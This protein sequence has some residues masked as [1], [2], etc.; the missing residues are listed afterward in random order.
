[1]R[2]RC[3]I[4]LISFTAYQDSELLDAVEKIASS[5]QVE[6]LYF[7]DSRG[8]VYPEE[9]YT[10]YSD[11]REI[12]R[13]PL[14]FHA[15]DNLGLAIE[16]SK[17]ALDAGCDLIDCSIN[18]YG[19]GGRNTEFVQ[20]I[21]LVRD[22]RPDLQDVGERE[23]ESVVETIGMPPKE[24]F[25]DLYYLTGLKNLEQEWCPILWESYGDM[26]FELLEKLPRRKYKEI[27]EVIEFADTAG[28]KQ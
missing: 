20:T 12:W 14:G 10:L 3:S 21:D 17:A 9:V 1:M 19:L 24:V 11:V 5:G 16:N 18:G 23:L 7:A 6:M 25:H 4:N 15:H 27:D 28:C 26:C 2:I 13:A 8:S 22:L